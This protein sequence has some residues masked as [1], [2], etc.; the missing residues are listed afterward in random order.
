MRCVG[1]LGRGKPCEL[2]GKRREVG[3][4]MRAQRLCRARERVPDLIVEGHGGPAI[5]RD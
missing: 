4:E 5:I 3:F 2:V 1:A